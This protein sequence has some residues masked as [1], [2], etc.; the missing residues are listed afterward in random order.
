MK[1]RISRTPLSIRA[2]A[3]KKFMTTFVI[4]CTLKGKVRKLSQVFCLL[5]SHTPRYD[6]DADGRR[7]SN[8]RQSRRESIDSINL[9]KLRL[10]P[11]SH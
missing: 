5:K 3:V 8:P 2:R 4:D 10:G 1:G 6:K 11:R 9:S 7:S